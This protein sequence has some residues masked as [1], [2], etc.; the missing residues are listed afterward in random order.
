MKVVLRKGDEYIQ[1][2]RYATKDQ[3]KS[4]WFYNGD[5]FQSIVMESSKGKTNLL[6]KILSLKINSNFI[7]TSEIMK[8]LDIEIDTHVST[9]C[10]EDAGQLKCVDLLKVFFESRSREYGY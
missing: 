2:F 8:L 9:I 6:L 10:K 1:V 4:Y 5:L 3:G 7:A